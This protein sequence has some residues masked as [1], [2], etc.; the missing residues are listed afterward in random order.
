MKIR[1]T[2][3]NGVVTKGYEQLEKLIKEAGDGEFIISRLSLSDP[4]TVEEW[5][6]TYFYLRDMLWE[7]ADTGY[8]KQELHMLIKEKCLLDLP[9]ESFVVYPIPNMSTSYLTP[10]GWR[11]FLKA[12]K[13]YSMDTFEI[14][15]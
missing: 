7:V 4:H 5:R 15:I 10:I 3:N 13:E 14:F 12:F 6:K 11:N 2:I 9:E 1:V 8:T